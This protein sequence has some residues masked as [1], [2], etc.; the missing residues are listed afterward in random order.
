MTITHTTLTRAAGAAAMAAGALFAAVQIGPTR[1]GP[2]P[3]R[4]AAALVARCHLGGRSD[5][6][7]VRAARPPARGHT[8]PRRRP[9][10]TSRADESRAR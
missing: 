2:Q 10:A 7:E 9:T 6:R 1:R 8:A 5:E 3:R 4:P